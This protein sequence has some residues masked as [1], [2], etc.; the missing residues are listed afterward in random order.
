MTDHYFCDALPCRWD[1]TEPSW[2]D[3]SVETM[4]AH[5]GTVRHNR[6]HLPVCPLCARRVVP[7]HGYAPAPVYPL[8]RRQP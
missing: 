8:P 4:D 2:T 7:S 5:T 1:G 3:A 6:V